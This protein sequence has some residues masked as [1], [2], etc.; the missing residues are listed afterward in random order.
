MSEN[1]EY[2]DLHCEDYIQSTI[3]CNMR[4]E[5]DTF[6]S[7]MHNKGKILDV[8]CGSGRDSLYFKTLGYEVTAI[9]PSL[10]L[11]EFAREYSKVEVL[12]ISVEDLPFE[13]YFDGIWA[14]ASLLHIT[15][16]KLSLVFDILYKALKEKG[17]LYASFKLREEDFTHQGRSFTCFT[18]ESLL[19]YISVNTPFT[20]LDI[21]VKGDKREKMKKEL[22][23]NLYL[24]KR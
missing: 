22:W 12:N 15:K 3:N 9:E 11:G 23:L 5:A 10:K 18:K 7:F 1:I 2:Y 8:G 17:I 14:N 13:N 20:L 21:F 24:E 19:E 6:L 4:E 16:D